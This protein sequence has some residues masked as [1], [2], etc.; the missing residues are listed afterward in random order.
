MFGHQIRKSITIIHSK[1]MPADAGSSGDE[2]AERLKLA[3]QF[4]ALIMQVIISLLVIVVSFYI[5]IKSPN[6]TVTKAASSFIGLVI[7]Y[8]IR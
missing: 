5:L 6:E 2:I 8:W 4:T 1:F 7:G 3:K